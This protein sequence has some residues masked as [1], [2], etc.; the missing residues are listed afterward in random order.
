MKK[1][2]S[3]EE[4]L[5]ILGEENQGEQDDTKHLSRTQHH[6]TNLLS[7]AAQIRRD[8]PEGSLENEAS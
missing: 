8:G 7:L 2:Y 3:V 5:K 1:K 4:I 6:G